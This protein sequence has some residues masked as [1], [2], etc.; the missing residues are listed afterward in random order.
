[1]RQTI[2]TNNGFKKYNQYQYRNELLA[3]RIRE[4]YP[5]LEFNEQA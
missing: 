5:K 3:Y 1:M 4:T 2:L